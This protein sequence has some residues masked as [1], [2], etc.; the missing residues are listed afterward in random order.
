MMDSNSVQQSQSREEL[1]AWIRKMNDAD[2]MRFSR[3]AALKCTP[4]PNSNRPV[5]EV[6]REQLRESR[7]EWR[8]RYPK[9]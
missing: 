9:D 2:L 3:A 4:M 6:F 8:R 1:R 5:R 7:A